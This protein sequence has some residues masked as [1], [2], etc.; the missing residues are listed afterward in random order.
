MKVKL[1]GDEERIGLQAQQKG[2]ERDAN[3]KRSNAKHLQC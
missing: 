1:E 3:T 2:K